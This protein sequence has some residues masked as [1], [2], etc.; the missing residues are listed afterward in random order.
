[1][2]LLKS[3]NHALSSIHGRCF[4]IGC[5]EDIRI[6]WINCDLFPKTESV[7]RF[8][9]TCTEDLFWL[10]ETKSNL[11]EC[12]H[13][14][15]YLNYGQTK[16]FF[17]SCFA[18]LNSSGK[19][20]LEFPDIVKISKKFVEIDGLDGNRDAYIELVRAVYAYDHS[21]AF[22]ENFDMKT[23]VFGWSGHF[24]CSLLKDIGFNQVLIKAP[25]GHGRREWRDTRIEALKLG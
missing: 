16:N 12:N 13:V 18:S 23:Y 3:I 4:N 20:I 1:M 8:D 15:G 22:L 24:V 14:I 6:G 21:D 19:L 10:Q 11:I 25:L 9:M 2:S 5:G 17:S 7:R